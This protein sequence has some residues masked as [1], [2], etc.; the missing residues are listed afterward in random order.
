MTTI[1]EH[2]KEGVAVH[3][4]VEEDVGGASNPIQQYPGAPMQNSHDG[5]TTTEIA[6]NAV[7]EGVNRSKIRCI[8]HLKSLPF[9]WKLSALVTVA[10]FIL[11]TIVVN[12]CNFVVIKRVY[13]NDQIT[14]YFGRGVIKGQL[15]PWDECAEWREYQN[16]DIGARM[17]AARVGSVGCVVIGALLILLL[18]KD[19]FCDGCWTKCFPMRM[20]RSVKM[21]FCLLAAGFQALVMLLVW[22]H[23]CKAGTIEGEDDGGSYVQTCSTNTSSF[24]VSIAVICLFM[25]DFVLVV[26]IFI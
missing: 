12:S 7:S 13:L 16:L 5:P 14:T 25:V 4:A 11:S 24:G 20:W 21:I 3:A 6:S 18:M 22:S 1:A 26:F 8:A 23:F 2:S 17:E 15:N 9:C 19:A 10:A